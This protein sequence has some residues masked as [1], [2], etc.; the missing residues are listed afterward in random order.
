MPG[1]DP[2]IWKGTVHYDPRVRGTVVRDSLRIID[3]SGSYHRWTAWTGAPSSSLDRFR[4]YFEIQPHNL[5]PKLK[6]K[7]VRA[8]P[9]I[10]RLSDSDSGEVVEIEIDTSAPR[11]G[12]AIV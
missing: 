4:I 9:F 2:N 10:D 11:P 7:C 6:L 1:L 5:G 8:R 12:T 3:S